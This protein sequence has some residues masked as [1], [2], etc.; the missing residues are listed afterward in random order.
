MEDKIDK[1]SRSKRTY[2]NNTNKGVPMESAID[3]KKS[4]P[5]ISKD[6]NEE[7]Q[8]QGECINEISVCM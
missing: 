3:L 2:Q 6:R 1:V 5:I 8:M 4:N 7:L